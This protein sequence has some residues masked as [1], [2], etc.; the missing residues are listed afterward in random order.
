MTKAEAQ[1]AVQEIRTLQKVADAE[2]ADKK[3]LEE[4]LESTKV[5]QPFIS[6]SADSL[7]SLSPHSLLED[8]IRSKEDSRT[9]YHNNKFFGDFGVIFDSHMQTRRDSQDGIAYSTV[10]QPSKKHGKSNSWIA[11]LQLEMVCNARSLVI[12]IVHCITDSL[13]FVDI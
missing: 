5:P 4:Q 2:E 7:E 6:T 10:S 8:A 9:S 11:P 12:F 3:S 13:N 1:K